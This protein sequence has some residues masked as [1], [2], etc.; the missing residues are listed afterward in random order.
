[1]GTPLLFQHKAN[2][3]IPL[4]YSLFE[5]WTT[6]KHTPISKSACGGKPKASPE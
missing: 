2:V 1:M 3:A 5:P 4:L 6:Q